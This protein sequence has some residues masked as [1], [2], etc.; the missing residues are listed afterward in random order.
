MKF[1]LEVLVQVIRMSPNPA[2]ESI[3]F[4][5]P[6]SLSINSFMS[7]NASVKN[8][9]LVDSH[10][11]IPSNMPESIAITFFIEPHTS[12]PII[13]NV[14]LT[15]VVSFSNIVFTKSLVSK[16]VDA[17]DKPIGEEVTTIEDVYEPYL[18]QNGFL[19]RTSRGRIVTDKAYKHLNIEK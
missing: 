3:V 11:F 2:K 6:P 5:L 9:A 14:S 1:L 4:L 17:R 13:S 7:F 12:T 15:L 16:F 8:S 10:V 18:L 19:K